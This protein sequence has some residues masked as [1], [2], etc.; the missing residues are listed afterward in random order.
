MKANWKHRK[1]GRWLYNSADFTTDCNDDAVNYS[2]H[3]VIIFNDQSR[4]V[5]VN[6]S[7]SFNT[8]YHNFMAKHP[9]FNRLLFLEVQIDIEKPGKAA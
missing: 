4:C 2:G 5:T 6:M 1:S 9:D 8:S 3:F 7:N